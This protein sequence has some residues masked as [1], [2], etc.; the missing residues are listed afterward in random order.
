[1]RKFLVKKFPILYLQLLTLIT[2]G[3]LLKIKTPSTFNEKLI[4]LNFN[5]QNPIKTQCA[6]KLMVRDY[7]KKLG[8]ERYLVKLY[9]HYLNADDIDFSALPDSFVLK[10]NHGSTYNILC[11]DKQQLDINKTKKKLSLWLKK[12]YSLEFAELH[13][14]P[15]T[16]VIVCEKYL[17]NDIMDYKIY[18]FNGVPTFVMLC[19]NPS[20]GKVKY[21]LYDFSWK[22]HNFLKE[23]LPDPNISRPSNLDEIYSL[24]ETLSKEFDFVRVDLYIVDNN[25]IIFGELT[26][27]P[28]AFI[29]RQTLPSYNS[30]MGN[31]LSI[32]DNE[33]LS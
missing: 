14:K 25:I 28:S 18:C 17:G 26:F 32:T 20:L 3:R 5:K 30:L 24:S 13:Y 8:L 31:L 27:T 33:N 21:Y 11:P 23:N 16:P 4:W 6:D 1:M 19:T 12:D 9:S 10:C 29:D 15:I 7:L 22:Y 2:Q